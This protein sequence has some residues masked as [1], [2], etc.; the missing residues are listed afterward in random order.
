MEA[1]SDGQSRQEAKIGEQVYTL[2]DI[3][4]SSVVSSVSKFLFAARNL[5]SIQSPRRA[6]LDI[7]VS[8]YIPVYRQN[9]RSI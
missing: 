5:F 8:V 4:A 2:W 3:A 9:D 6:K 7:I 1:K